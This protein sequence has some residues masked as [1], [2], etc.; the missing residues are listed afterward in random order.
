MDVPPPHH[1]PPPQDHMAAAVIAAE[2]MRGGEQGQQH[3]VMDPKI[4][5]VPNVG[6]IPTAQEPVSDGAPAN[7]VGTNA[8]ISDALVQ[9]ESAPQNPNESAKK[10]DT[11]IGSN[12]EEVIENPQPAI[13]SSVEKQLEASS[14]ANAPP[15]G[16]MP[17]QAVVK[18]EIFENGEDKDPA[19]STENESLPVI[20][21]TCF[22]D[23]AII[24]AVHNKMTEM[25]L[26]G[27]QVENWLMIQVM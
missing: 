1:L 10:A 22:N 23:D 20:P 12:C 15:T 3:V 24:A 25:D 18:Q 4:N 2:A 6:M 13:Q 11:P 16:V 26:T 7:V 8:H 14:E 17:H 9:P 5:P 19:A 21:D 27:I